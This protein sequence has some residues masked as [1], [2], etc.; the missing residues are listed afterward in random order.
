MCVELGVMNG[1]G[2]VFVRVDC[3]VDECMVDVFCGDL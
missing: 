1:V 3:R 2:V